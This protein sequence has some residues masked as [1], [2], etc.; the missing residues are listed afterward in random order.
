MAVSVPYRRRDVVSTG[1]ANGY[2]IEFM[3]DGR[4]L[5]V[6]R[7]GRLKII[8][9]SGQ[10]SAPLAGLPP[11]YAGGPQGLVGAIA[12]RE[13]ATNRTVYIAYTAPD[14]N[15]PSPAPRLAG[16]LTIARARLSSDSSAARGREC[17]P[18]RGRDRRADDSGARRHAADLLV[19]SGR[20]RHPLRGLAAAAAA[21]QPDGEAAAHQHRRHGAEGQPVRRTAERARRDLRARP[22][23]RSGPRVA[24]SDRTPVGERARTAR[25]RRDQRDPEGE[26]LRLSRHR[27]RARLQR[28]RD[29]QGSNVAGRH[30]AAR[31]L[32]DAGHCTRRHHLLQR[33]AVSRLAGRSVRRGAGRQ[34]SRPS[35]APGRAG[36]RRGAP[37]DRSRC[38]DPRRQ[39]RAGRGAVRVDRS[40]RRE[41]C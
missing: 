12:D 23:R 13:F 14:P 39:G 18:Q 9:R 21:R 19:H 17:A 33:Q 10:I 3:P 24:S 40:R 41:D 2:S 38:A 35:R 1:I 30:G 11:I 6:E 34:A 20:C 26:E 25:R 22:S 27:L 36:D 15:A 5:L 29:Q 37:A 32:L 28:Q 4:I 31:V 7:P 16:V 8:D